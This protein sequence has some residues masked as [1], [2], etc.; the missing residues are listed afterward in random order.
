MRTRSVRNAC[1]AAYRVRKRETKQFSAATTK[2]TPKYVFN[3]CAVLICEFCLR[4]HFKWFLFG[5]AAATGYA[6]ESFHFEHGGS[7][8]A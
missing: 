6:S 4:L 1:T 7:T 2:K 5:S 3:I 8:T